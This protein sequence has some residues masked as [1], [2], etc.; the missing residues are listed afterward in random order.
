MTSEKPKLVGWFSV[1][2]TSMTS[3]DMTMSAFSCYTMLI[4]GG[5]NKFAAIA[6]PTG[7]VILTRKANVGARFSR[8]RTAKYVNDSRFCVKPCNRCRFHSIASTT[9]SLISH[10][11][12]LFD[13]LQS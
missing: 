4:W 7:Q 5:S 9:Q 13:A 8:Y 1:D 11:D 3:G 6:K 2:S 10:F 12:C